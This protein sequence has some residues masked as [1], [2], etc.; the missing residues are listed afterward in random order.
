MAIGV[1]KRG[2]TRGGRDLCLRVYGRFMLCICMHVHVRDEQPFFV[3]SISAS[4][5][6]Q[7]PVPGQSL[8]LGDRMRILQAIKNRSSG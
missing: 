6:R 8:A 1:S 5:V 7:P 2:V 4:F 3:W